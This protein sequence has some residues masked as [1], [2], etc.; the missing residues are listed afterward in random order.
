MSIFTPQ[1]MLAKEDML[2][3]LLNENGKIMGANV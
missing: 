1:R 2:V 3:L